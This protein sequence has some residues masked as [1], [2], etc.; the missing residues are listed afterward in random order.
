MR[1]FRC[2]CSFRVF[3]HNRRSIVITLPSPIS[4]F[5]SPHCSSL[6]FTLS[7]SYSGE[8]CPFGIQDLRCLLTKCPFGIQQCR[9]RAIF[10]PSSL[11]NPCL[12][13]FQSLLRLT[14]AL[15]LGCPFGS[16]PAVCYMLLCASRLLLSGCPFDN[17]FA[18]WL[19][20]WQRSRR[21]VTCFFAQAVCCALLWK[22]G[23]C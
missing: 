11:P 8:R 9:F 12:D 14:T 22:T 16:S 3:H 20:V 7:L 2:S 6:S 18:S 23:L 19:P 4:S 21:F 17:S 13:R 10:F 5:P 1:R 15:L